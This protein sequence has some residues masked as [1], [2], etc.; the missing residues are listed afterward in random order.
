MGLALLNTFYET[1][2]AQIPL[3]LDSRYAVMQNSLALGQDCA[4][5]FV[6]AVD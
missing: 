2:L 6:A 5:F 4:V 3:R 1:R